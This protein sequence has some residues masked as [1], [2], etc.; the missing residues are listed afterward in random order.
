MTYI[1]CYNRTN[2][3]KNQ[4]SSAVEFLFV[5]EARCYI[6]PTINYKTIA[7]PISWSSII[8]LILPRLGSEDKV[9]ASTAFSIGNL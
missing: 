3:I 4:I 8:T 1:V 2:R 9:N 7:S 5:I 6:L